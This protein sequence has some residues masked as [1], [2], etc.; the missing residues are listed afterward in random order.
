MWALNPKQ[1]NHK[2]IKVYFTAVDIAGNATI[3]MME[4]LCSNKEHLKLY[5]PTSKN[6][7]S[8]M[9]LDGPNIHGKVF[10]DTGDE[11]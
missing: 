7:S 4:R 9:K 2:I 11:V 6:N 5:V 10:E 3:A 1:Y 8:Q